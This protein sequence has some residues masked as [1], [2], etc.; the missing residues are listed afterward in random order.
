MLWLID[1]YILH[2]LIPGMSAPL[3]LL[4]LTVIGAV[5]YVGMLWYGAQETFIEVVNLLI[6]RKPPEGVEAAKP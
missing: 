6:R 5:S 2:A 1:H 3:H 4:V